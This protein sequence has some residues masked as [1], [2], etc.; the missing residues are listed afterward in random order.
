MLWV[1]IEVSC[2]DASNEYP[3]HVFL[4]QLGKKKSCCVWKIC[5]IKGCIRSFVNL[6]STCTN[7][8]DL[9]FLGLKKN[10]K[11]PISGL[12]G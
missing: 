10:V 11:F 5:L 1:L 3:Q 2:K 4:K 9:R 12:T 6:N 7:I 8:M